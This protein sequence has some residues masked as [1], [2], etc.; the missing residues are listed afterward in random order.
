[1]MRTS[2]S[3][4]AY[5]LLYLALAVAASICCNK[6][7]W[8][9][10]NVT[11]TKSTARQHTC[12]NGQ[13]QQAA[14]GASSGPA[15]SLLLTGVRQTLERPLRVNNYFVPDQKERFVGFRCTGLYLI[16]VVFQLDWA[17]LDRPISQQTTAP[18]LGDGWALSR[19]VSQQRLVLQLMLIDDTAL[20]REQTDRNLASLGWGM[21][22]NCNTI[23]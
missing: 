19:L 4:C 15:G 22:P 12:T 1:M 20:D 5:Q 21:M 18:A 7:L 17:T 13:S 14:S 9:R 8:C 16:A 6:A 11:W 2:V 3:F 10:T 23:C